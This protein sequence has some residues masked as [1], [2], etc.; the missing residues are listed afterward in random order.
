MAAV[1][2]VGGDLGAAGLAL[3]EMEGLAGRGARHQVVATGG[4]GSG[5]ALLIDESYNANPASMR[6]TL[7]QLAAT[8]AR[9]RV[10]ILGA[11]KELGEK[12]GS[13]H[14]ALADPIIA[15]QVDRVILVGPEMVALADALGKTPAAQLAP[16]FAMAHVENV[17]EAAKLLD[18]SAAADWIG[19]GDAVLVKGSNSVGLG[20]LVRDL[21]ARED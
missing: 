1:R 12:S 10:A 3:A 11:M 15:A 4:D 21:A 9:R 5:K 7:Q 6:A 13:F 19:G 2:A 16:G 17:A 20:T 18:G 8:T 14:A